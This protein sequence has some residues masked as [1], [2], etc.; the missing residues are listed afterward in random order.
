MKRGL[1][2]KFMQLDE[3]KECLDEMQFSCDISIA[4]ITPGNFINFFSGF[5]LERNKKMTAIFTVTGNPV[6]V[7][8]IHSV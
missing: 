2:M 5:C 3:T 1:M 4:F 8:E 6:Y 7:R